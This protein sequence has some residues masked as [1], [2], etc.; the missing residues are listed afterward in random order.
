MEAKVVSQHS[1][2]LL[3]QIRAEIR[4]RHYSIRTEEV[5]VDWSRRF[6][7][8]HDKR[9]PKEMRASSKGLLS[10]LTVER[11]ERP[12]LKFVSAVL[13]TFSC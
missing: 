2:K 8:F 10:P 7:L 5:Y 1:P 13:R 12:G 3:D 9:H 11:N 6:I 4:V